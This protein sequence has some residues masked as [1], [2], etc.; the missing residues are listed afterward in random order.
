MGNFSTH[1]LV[2]TTSKSDLLPWKWMFHFTKPKS[3]Q[4]AENGVH[5]HWQVVVCL[6]LHLNCSSASADKVRHTGDF[7]AICFPVVTFGRLT[8]S[9][10]GG[11][12][13]QGK[14]MKSCVRFASNSFEKI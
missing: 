3:L 8:R 4:H 7:H 14:M 1:Y 2:V 10:L 6:L 5:N 11:T 12:V 9:E 13:W